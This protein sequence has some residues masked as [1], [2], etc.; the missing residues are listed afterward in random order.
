MKITLAQLP[1]SEDIKK[2]QYL[3]IKTLSSAKKDEWVVFPEGMLS[4][5]FPQEQSFIQS[6]D[7][8][9]KSF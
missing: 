9:Q 8:R 6:I 7:T 3:M 4:G 5:Y 2:N 1:I